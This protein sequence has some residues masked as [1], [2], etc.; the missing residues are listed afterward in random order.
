M[1]DVARGPEWWLASDG[2]WYPPAADLDPSV[3]ALIARTSSTPQGGAS[4]RSF[5]ARL[6]PWV[7]LLL[8]V[9]WL[10]VYLGVPPTQNP[11]LL[12]RA[13]VTDPGLSV[14]SSTGPTEEAI[15]IEQSPFA[16]VQALAS[17]G[18]AWA[19]E[20]QW[21]T[22]GAASL[23]VTVYSLPSGSDAAQSLREFRDYVTRPSVA[24]GTNSMLNNVIGELSIPGMVNGVAYETD[25]ASSPDTL[26]YQIGFSVRNDLV[27]LSFGAG[28]IDAPLITSS[29]V[30][31]SASTQ[32]RLAQLIL[33]IGISHRNDLWIWMSTI[34]FLFAVIV[35]LIRAKGRASRGT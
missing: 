6:F 34:A 5:R 17:K 32:A 35:L 33:P 11:S 8:G 28:S 4:H 15:S 7:P 19:Y 1:S 30:S 24:Y 10:I 25:V 16:T 26:N 29:E 27:V 12:A 21:N 23:T 31:A 18:Q 20:R 2:R 3:V 14:L 9:L 13:V 22:T